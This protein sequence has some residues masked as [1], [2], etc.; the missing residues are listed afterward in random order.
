MAADRRSTQRPL[1]AAARSV[2]EPVG[3]SERPNPPESQRSSGDASK[4][5]F[6][7]LVD[8]HLDAPAYATAIVDEALR[9]LDGMAE[10]DR[11]FI[12][13]ALLAALDEGEPAGA[14]FALVAGTTR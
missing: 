7:R 3:A 11:A 4:G 13:A 9:H 10:G 12:Q 2:G 5:P 8:G 14:L 6:Q 1:P